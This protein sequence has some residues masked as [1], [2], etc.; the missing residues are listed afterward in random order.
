MACQQNADAAFP[1]KNS[2]W[3]YNGTV[4]NITYVWGNEDGASTQQTYC[5]VTFTPTSTKAL[6]VLGCHIAAEPSFACAGWGSGNGASTIS[7]SPYH[8][9]IDN[10]CSPLSNCVTLGS[11]DQQMASNT[12]IVPPTCSVTPSSAEICAGATAIFTASGINGSGGAPYTFA[13]TGPNGFSAS[14]ASINVGVAGVYSVIVSDSNGVP[15]EAPCTVNLV[16]N[17][18]PVPSVADE[19]ACVGSTA[20]FSTTSTPG[21]SYQWYLN[22]VLIPGATNNSYTTPILSLADNGGIYKVIVVDGNHN[23][24]CDGEDSGILTVN[25]LPTVVANDAEVCTGFTVQLTANPAGG[26]WSGANVSASGLFDA[27]GLV[28]GPY[29]VTYTYSDANE[30]TNSDGAVVTVNALPTIVANDAEVCT[31]FTVQLTANPAGGTWSG[32]NVSASGLFDASGLAAGPYNVT[33]TYSDANECANSDGAVV[34][35]NALPTVAANDAEVCTGFT[36]QLT[37]NPAGGT[38]SGANVSASGLFDAS[39]LAAGPYNVTYT[40]SDAN[41]C[42]NSDGAVVTVNALPTVV[43]NDAE[44][45]TGFMVQLTAN[46]AGGTWSGANVSASG[47]FDASGLAAGPYNVTYTYSDANQCTNSDGAVVTVNA[48]PT[49]VANDAEVCTGFTVQLTANPA[50]GTWSGANVSASGL[51]DASGLAAGPYNVTYTYSDA[52]ECTNSDGAVVT[53]NAL[54]T[55]VANDAEVCT[56][57]TVQLTAN[58]AGGTWSGANVSASG[59]FDASGLA[60]GPYNVTYTYSDANECTNS[61][62]AVVTVNALPTVVANDAEVCTGF[63]VQLT[64]NP[65]GGTWSG[66]NVSASGLFDASGLAA[67]PYNVTY[68]YSDANECTNSDG[69]V[70]TVNDF[71][72]IVCPSPALFDV[73]CGVSASVAQAATDSKFSTWFNSFAGLNSDPN[74]EIVA[75][76][77]VY[78]PSSADPDGDSNAPLNPIIGVP[79]SIE[80]SVTVTWTIRNTDTGCESSCSSTF[81]MSFNCR[82]GCQTTPTPVACNGESSGSIQVLG[83]NGI[84]PYNFYLYNSSD[85]N[86]VIDSVMGVND[87]PGGALFSNLPAGTYT[88]LITDAVQTLEDATVCDA[89]ISQPDALSLSLQMEPE[90]CID[91]ATGSISATFS[92]GVSPYMVSIDNGPASEQLSPFTF[93]GLNTGNHTVKII[94]ANGCEISEDIEVELIPCDDAHCTYTQG[95]Y[96]NYGG[97]GCVPDLGSVNSQIMMIRALNQVGGSF[98]FG[99]VNTGNYFLLKLS[100]V[101]GVSI[102][103]DN[104]IYKMLPG[105]GSPRKLVGFATYDTPATWSDG[106]P[107][108]ASGSRKGKINNNLLSQTM[109]LFFNL[110]ISNALASVE[111]ESTFAT[112]SDV[113][114]GA[115]MPDMETVQIFNIPQ[116]VIDY[117]NLN[118]GA[119]VGNLFILANKALGGEYIN[120]LSHSNIN[121][122]VDAIN[123]G[124]DECRINVPVPEDIEIKTVSLSDGLIVTAYPNPFKEYLMLNYKFNYESNVDIQIFDTKGSLLYEYKDTDA[125]FGKELKL[126]INFNHAGGELFI[127]KLMTSKE[128]ITHKIFSANQ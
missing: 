111:L 80:T 20:T 100:D 88:I 29:N 68:T 91:T 45:C 66:A 114:C 49:V 35:V 74:I 97:L 90:N 2:I 34:T 12:I 1:D 47:L 85:L 94:D 126:D 86:N 60:A 125:Y 87:E 30:C 98:N 77:Y 59:L 89:T 127:L 106:D 16:V 17:D 116:N 7:G 63:T 51:F 67:G 21:Y 110:Q 3:I 23:T 65:A 41:E 103:R 79:G 52:N 6:L 53:V 69:A 117:L 128:V 75:V 33:Y 48:L 61:D 107:I 62:G 121:A 118:G 32:A 113:E 95:F 42:T 82:I 27:S 43:A 8:F 120:G 109:V 40:Y 96:G 55:V 5:T 115:N 54:P 83:S 26:T 31:G 73:D 39:G 22:N 58:P 19:E 123:R 46:P 76:Q 28:A 11:Q 4:S 13:W 38:W 112:A 50:G 108:Y 104:N 92:G 101:N 18:N 10:I 70:V 9:H 72:E 78:S 122:A 36:V 64:A 25:A 81:T 71:P 124:Y 56:G 15:A 105:G 14:T 99:S 24:D 84:P 57:F 119:T 37:A 44:V 102:P 93:T